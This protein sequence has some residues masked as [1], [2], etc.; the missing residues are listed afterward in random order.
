VF[1]LI[2]ADPLEDVAIPGEKYSFGVL[3]LAQALG[4]FAS[5]EATGR[6]VVRIHLGAPDLKAV[7]RTCAL[8]E[9]ALPK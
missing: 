3:E 4:D 9:S 5:L 1:V 6:R 7:D 8:L 2:T